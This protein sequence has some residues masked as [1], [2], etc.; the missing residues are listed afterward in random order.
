MVGILGLSPISF[1]SRTFTLIFGFVR[2]ISLMITQPP[3]R[4]E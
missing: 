2:L 1:I 4:R 3:L